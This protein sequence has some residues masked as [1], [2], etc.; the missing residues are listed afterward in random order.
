MRSPFF[1]RGIR[2]DFASLVLRHLFNVTPSVVF[3]RSNNMDNYISIHTHVRSQCDADI[4]AGEFITRLKELGVHGACITDHGGATAIE[5]YRRAFKKAGLKLVPGCELYVDGGKFG[6]RHLIVLAKDDLGWQGIG[7]LITDSERNLKNGFPVIEIKRLSEL[8]KP[9]RGHVIATSA[10][11]YG[12]VCSVFLRNEEVKKKA[13]KL[14]RKQEKYVSPEDPRVEDAEMR[15][16]SL[17]NELKELQMRRDEMNRAAGMKFSVREKKLKRL[18]GTEEYAPFKEAL[19]SDKAAQEKAIK[20]LPAIK[21]EIAAKKKAITAVSREMRAFDDSIAK[22]NAL[23][24]ERQDILKES[25]P[26]EELMIRATNNAKLM[27]RIFGEGCF[28]M[29]VQYHGL[30]EEAIAYPKAVEVAKALGI[31]LVAS[32]DVHILRNTEDD[33]LKRCLLRSL[34]YGKS[35]EEEQPGDKELYLKSRDELKAA[36]TEIISKDDAE[37]ALDNTVRIFDACDVKFEHGKHYPKYPVKDSKAELERLVQ[38]GIKRRFPE[39]FPDGRYEERLKHELDIIEGMGYSDYHLVVA[40]YIQYGRELGRLDSQEL[41]D[42]APLTID[43]LKAYVKEHG[44]EDEPSYTIGTGRGSAVGSL[45]CYLMGITNLDPIKYDLLFERFLNPERISMPD[46]D[47]DFSRSVRSK[48]VE[49]VKAKYGEDAVSGIMTVTMQAPKGAINIAA[50]FYGLRK[51]GNPMT[52][53]GYKLSDEVDKDPKISFDTP[54]DPIT[55]KVVDKNSSDAKVT[56]YEYLM[57]LNKGDADAVEIIRWAKVLEGSVTSYSAHAAGICITDGNPVSDFMPERY[58]SELNIMCTQCD[59]NELEEDGLLKFDFLG[60]K[61]LDIITDALKMIRRNYGL[62][63]DPLK[64]DINDESVYKDIFQQGR[65]RAVFQFESDGMRAMLK[66]FRPENFEDLIILN[67][68]FRPGP[69]QYLDD[70][71]DVK[72]GK[73]AT[74]LVPELKPILSKTYGAIVY[75]EQVMEIVQKLAGYTLGGADTVRKYMSKKK[76]EALA[77]ERPVFVYGSAE[78]HIKG[79]VGNGIPAEAADKLFDQMMDFASYAFNKSHAAAYSYNAYVTAWLKKHYPEEFFAA[80][81]NYADKPEKAAALLKEATA[82]GVKILLPS[83]NASEERFT[84]QASAKGRA[85]RF[86][87]AGIRAVSQG[88]KSIA[89]E[90]RA[91]GAYRDLKD[92]LIRNNGLNRTVVTNLI[93]A[94]ALDCLGRSRR[95]MKEAAAAIRPMASSLRKAEDALTALKAEGAPEKK[96]MA[97]AS[98]IAKL[99]SQMDEALAWSMPDDE[100]EKLALEKA[101]LGIYISGSPL[102]QYLPAAEQGAASCADVSEGSAKVLGIITSLTL[103]KR[104]KDGKPMAFLTLEDKAG[105]IPV[106]V[107]TD[108]YSKFGNRLKEGE[109]VILEGEARLDGDGDD[110]E[111]KLYASGISRAKGG[112]KYYL[113]PVESKK[114]FCDKYSIPAEKDAFTKAYADKDGLT[115]LLYFKDTSKVARTTFLASPRILEAGAREISL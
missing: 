18:E 59:M 97:K 108:A 89:D 96:V 27:M 20:E 61:S 36:L 64:I 43:G 50:K 71:I 40:D 4:K 11:V 52:Q 94:G 3:E 51:D 81:L 83:V 69:L 91:G 74:Y 19:D 13:D 15:A 24:D 44:C 103:K 85:V 45:V 46:I 12:V 113:L 38:D 66:R 32:N 37:E 35:F 99:K 90:R 55:G 62:S 100:N 104:R 9:Y 77:A 112:D 22:W 5:E 23:E 48:C 73:P 63:I 114:W 111:L 57:G 21:E 31:P 98:E 41:I 82:C 107:F 102:D 84:V 95:F 70:V 60:L 58:N 29:E 56:L 54:V 10:C 28:Y 17:G 39:G 79:C 110:A 92:F 34:R 26:E 80:A 47:T 75:Q 93:D 6:R 106:C 88:A 53:L 78:R 109:V 101:L 7:K 115:M 16:D 67:S 105:S 87:L 1:A 25:M 14:V 72:D 2:N 33:R 76:S 86:G 30:P 42:N 8:M 68:M 49:Y 65:T